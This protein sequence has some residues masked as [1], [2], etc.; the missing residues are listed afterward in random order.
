M[1]CFMLRMLR[2][3][4]CLLPLPSLTISLP[5]SPPLTP[6]LFPSSLPPG[7]VEVVPVDGPLPYNG[8]QQKSLDE[9]LQEMV[10]SK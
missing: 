7:L 2:L 4:W 9:V 1:H 3:A 5:F 10:I 8:D 6:P